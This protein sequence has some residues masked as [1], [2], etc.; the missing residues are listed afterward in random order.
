MM[1]HVMAQTAVE[2]TVAYAQRF[3]L[4][5]L[6]QQRVTDQFYGLMSSSYMT[7]IVVVNDT[8]GKY[9]TA[10]TA[11][12]TA[13]TSLLT[14]AAQSAAFNSNDLGKLVMFRKTGDI[15]LGTIET[16]PSGTTLT[17]AG[18]NLPAANLA[19]ID[20][21][22]I[23]PTPPTSTYI[24]LAGLA[25]MR[26]GGQ[27]KMELESSST[28]A[29]EPLSLEAFR[30][31]RS[32]APQNRNKIVWVLSGD[33]ILLQKGS[34]LSAYGTLTLRYPRVPNN[35]TA[36]SDYI[37][38]PDG[39]ATAL[40]VELLKRE[41]LRRFKQLEPN[42]ED[43]ALLVKNMYNTFAT[44]VQTEEVDQKTQALS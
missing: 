4:I 43:L 39:A 36:D 37:D 9:A 12:W 2:D 3:E 35:L 33:Q 27:I 16:V 25:I 29:T 26:V 13:A 23:C 8:T 5:N 38:L 44:I 6:A 40:M 15:Y 24:S 19:T 18:F 41:L 14:V 17:L 11:T 31:F 10:A 30:N 34:A 28:M 22:L 1:K 21:V 42:M 7:P 32:S 20:E